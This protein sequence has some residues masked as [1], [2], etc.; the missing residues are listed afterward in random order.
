MLQL[1]SESL[2]KIPGPGFLVILFVLRIKADKGRDDNPCYNN[3][4]SKTGHICGDD[5]CYCVGN[6]SCCNNRSLGYIPELP[7]NI[8]YVDFSHNCIKSVSKIT[9][10]NITGLKIEQ[11]MLRHNKI[12]NISKTAFTG[13]RYI[14]RLDL[15]GNKGINQMQLSSS[16]FSIQKEFG[17]KVILDNCG[18][19]SIPDDFFKGLLKTKVVKISLRKNRMKKFNERLL[20]NLPN[21]KTLDLSRNW[22]EAITGDVSG[23]RYGHK[24]LKKLILSHNAFLKFPPRLCDKKTSKSLY[25]RLQTLDLSCNFII[26]PV[27]KA[28]S[29]L[30]NL[31]YFYLAKNV[32]QVIQNDVFSDLISLKKLYLSNMRRTIE[33]MSPQAFNISNL[34]SLHFGH[35]KI[36]FKLGTD[37]QFDNLFKLMP[38][39]ESIHLGSNVF[40]MGN[41]SMVRMLKPLKRLKRLYLDGINLRGI[42]ENF[43]SMFQNLSH[44]DLSNN[45]ISWIEPSAFRNVINLK[46]LYLEEN[47]IEEISST[48]FPDSVKNSLMEIN[49][50]DNPFSCS[51]C[52]NM[53]FRNWIDESGI[54]F[55]GWPKFYTCNYPPCMREKSIKDYHPKTEDCKEKN[56]MIAVYVSIAVFLILMIICGTVT[57]RGR[58]YLRYWVIRL[59]R[60]CKRFYENDS[61]R[62]GLLQKDAAYDVYI[63]YNDNDRSFIRETLLPFMEEQHGYRLFIRDREAEQGAKV[64]IMV[65]SIYRSNYV[66]AVISRKFLKDQWCEFQ[67]AVTIDRQVDLK[68][69]HLL[70]I[71]LEDVDKSLLSKSWCVLLTRTPTAEWCDKKNDIKRKLFE[72]QIITTIPH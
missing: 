12:E 6:W 10:D 29:C 57:Y 23:K 30:T 27:R 52:R 46:K 71:T 63:I 58:W 61:E 70:L 25:P 8:K 9:F 14:Q 59:R 19:N 68:R 39:L 4:N 15:H 36:D 45:K 1:R 34:R 24:T 41:E 56:P 17:L 32:L 21:L 31:E 51:P 13:L 35:N 22:I 49:L 16:F 66:I 48:S 69:N 7:D 72:H 18:L 55:L 38:N 62:Q 50:A 37:I 28:W 44:L 53:W 2:S 47:M 40:T 26:F 33:K 64:D 3:L 43:I 20:M 5:Q 11:L 65:E 42:P 60:K 67:L 54:K